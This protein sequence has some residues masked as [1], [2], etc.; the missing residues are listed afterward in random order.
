MGEPKSLTWTFARQVMMPQ[1]SPMGSGYRHHHQAALRSPGRSGHRL[2]P[3]KG[4][5]SAARLSHLPDCWTAT[6]AGGR[7]LRRQRA[8]RQ[9][10]PAGTAEVHDTLP[11]D[12]RPKLVRGDNAFGNNAMM[13][14]LVN[15]QQPY[16]FELRTLSTT[17]TQ[18]KLKENHV[19]INYR[20]MHQL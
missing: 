18:R 9:A 2:Q 16:L 5:T 4:R 3:K 1:A 11:A 6:G 14:A 10:Y 7:S 8:H 12:R 19:S 17:K 13:T 20:R 15:R